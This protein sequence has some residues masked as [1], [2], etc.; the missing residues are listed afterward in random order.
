MSQ[1]IRAFTIG[2]IS[3]RQLNGLFSLNDLHRASGGEEKYE[4]NRFLRN[5]QTKAL[6]AE[7][8]TAGAKAF[9]AKPKVGTY[10]CRE[11]VIAYAAW[12]SAAF[13][14]KVIR[15][16]LATV[17]PQAAPAIDYE[18]MS[19][20][21]KQDLHDLVQTI[22]EAGIQ[23]HAETWARLHRKFR[24]NSYHELPA[25][26]YQAAMQYLQDKLPRRKAITCRADL[27][28]TQKDEQGRMLNW[29][30]PSRPGNWHEHYGIGQAWFD[31]IVELARVN[32]REAYDALRFAGPALTQYVN[33]GHA[34]GFVEAFA[35]YAI[36][37][38]VQG[39]PLQLPFAPSDLG[40]PPP[41]GLDYFKQ[42]GRA[43]LLR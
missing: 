14:L 15:V 23:G 39:K 5:D 25:S 4:P 28:F 26:Q 12:I 22:V 2:E 7:I 10:A 33:W 9:E 34:E 35:R 38:M 17:Q 29:F 21:Q 32:P 18:R 36:A 20:A 3:V 30:I 6:V 27:S 19:P 41:H 11:L 1:T 8:E 37:A 13:H 16:F 43:H 40:T 42:Q 31:E 24:V